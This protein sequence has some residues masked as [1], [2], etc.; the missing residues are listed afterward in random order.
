VLERRY[1]GALFEE[2]PATAEMHELRELFTS[3]LERRLE[4]DGAGTPGTS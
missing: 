1:L 2:L 3:F 4:A